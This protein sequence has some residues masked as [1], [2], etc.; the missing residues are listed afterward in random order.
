M[1]KQDIMRHSFASYWLAQHGDINKLTLMMGH[2]TTTMLW[3]HYHK[4]A[5]KAEA[6]KYWKITPPA[7]RK[8]VQFKAA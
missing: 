3:K 1:W 5:K 7:R 6:E 2:T 4:A 8:I